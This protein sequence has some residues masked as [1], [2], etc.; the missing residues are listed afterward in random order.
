[1]DDARRAARM[2]RSLAN[3]AAG[4]THDLAAYQKQKT[5]WKKYTGN[6]YI[7]RCTDEMLEGIKDRHDLK[8]VQEAS[9]RRH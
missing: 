1:M 5:N 8:N 2:K 6:I 7:I 9:R 4:L 3:R